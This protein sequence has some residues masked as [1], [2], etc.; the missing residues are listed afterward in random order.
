MREDKEDL[1]TWEIHLVS[2]DG[3]TARVV[4]YEGVR[5]VHLTGNTLKV[6][7]M[8][9]STTGIFILKAGDFARRRK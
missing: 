7:G 4:T 8:D 5:G 9:D 6:T 2:G 3:K 1:Y